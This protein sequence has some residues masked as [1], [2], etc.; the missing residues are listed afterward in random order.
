VGVNMLREIFRRR[1]AKPCACNRSKSGNCIKI[2]DNVIDRT[3][4]LVSLRRANHRRALG[5]LLLLVIAYAATVETVHSH[6]TRSLDNYGVAAFSDADGSHPSHTGHSH[7]A[8][9]SIC[10]FQQQLF[11]GL[12]HAPLFALTP[13]TQ[14]ASVSAPTVVYSSTSITRP[15]GRAPPLG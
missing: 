11:N 13:S 15:S 10:E 8:E 5:Y 6:G 4:L 3:T 9:C 12:V 7:L 1:P 2:H 14:I